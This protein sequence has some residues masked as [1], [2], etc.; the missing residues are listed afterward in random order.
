MANIPTELILTELSIKSAERIKKYM[1][2]PPATA[3]QFMNKTKYFYDKRPGEW[4]LYFLRL[5][6]QSALL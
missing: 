1:F 5:D 4:F 6:S 3:E 2:L